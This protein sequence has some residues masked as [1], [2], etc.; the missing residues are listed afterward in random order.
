M[1]SHDDWVRAEAGEFV[2]AGC[3]VPE[4][5]PAHWCTTCNAEFGV[6][7]HNFDDL[8][9]GDDQLRPRPL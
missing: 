6:W 9:M 5:P 7:D 8:N 4:R 2:L 1:P 3:V